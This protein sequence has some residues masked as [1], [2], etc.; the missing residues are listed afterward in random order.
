MTL[1]Q[2][3]RYRWNSRTQPLPYDRQRFPH[4]NVVGEI[5]PHN[6]PGIAQG[7][8]QLRGYMTNH[9]TAT[10]QLITYRQVAGQPTSYEVLAADSR[11]L[12]A[13][14]DYLGAPK[15][16]QT[17][18]DLNSLQ[19]WYLLGR[20][21]VPEATETLQFWQCPPPFGAMIENRIRNQYASMVGV[22]LKPKSP[23]R[24]GED[25]SH[26]RELA[27]FLRELAGQLEAELESPKELVY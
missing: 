4:R 11:Q 17:K 23:S 27:A 13:L 20:I 8:R 14:L 19:K 24:P 6:R 12:K 21:R 2:L 9:P 15:N 22:R 10:P 16:G 3:R 5:K 1:E 7:I 26:E 18:H 25:I